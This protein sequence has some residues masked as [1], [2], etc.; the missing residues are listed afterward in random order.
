MGGVRVSVEGEGDNSGENRPAGE[1]D[2]PA[3]K[4]KNIKIASQVSCQGCGDRSSAWCSRKHVNR[5]CQ[6]CGKQLN[7]LRPHLTGYH[8]LRNVEETL[9]LVSWS[10]GRVTGKLTCRVCDKVGLDRHLADL[11]QLPPNG[12]EGNKPN[13][14]H[15]LQVGFNPPNPQTLYI[16]PSSTFSRTSC[17]WIP[18]FLPIHPCPHAYPSSG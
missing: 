5:E 4:E 8:G 17:H 1:G 2:S 16:G 6:I 3:G 15:G 13:F 14:P 7:Y 12:A 10:T 9:L 11:H 18:G